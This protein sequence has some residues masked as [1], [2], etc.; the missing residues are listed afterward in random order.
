[1]NNPLKDGPWPMSR[2]GRPAKIQ[3]S[4]QN[5]LVSKI[6]PLDGTFKAVQY[7][8]LNYDSTN[9]PL[10]F[11]AT[12]D[13]DTS[14][15]NILITG[16]VHGYETSGAH[17]AIEFMVKKA[18]TYQSNFNLICAPCISPWGYE[19][20]NRWNPDANDPN[21]NFFKGTLFPSAAK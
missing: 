11:I 21:R 7:G 3:R 18:S 12:R 5:D 9:Y 14:K 15:P 8:E 16:G 4:Y 1:M 2:H 17:G 19:T 6:K 20:I 13:M 10:Y